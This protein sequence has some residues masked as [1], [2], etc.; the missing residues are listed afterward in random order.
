M[1]KD[2]RRGPR[3]PPT[4]PQPQPKHKQ[5]RTCV[6]WLIMGVALG[7]VGS[8][9]LTSKRA[10]PVAP[11]ETAAGPEGTGQPPAAKPRFMFEEILSDNEVDIGQTPPPPP[12]APRPQPPATPPT[13]VDGRTATPELPPAEPTEQP[14]A[15]T[16][17]V[18]VG[19]FGRAADA[20]RLRAQLALLGLSTSVQSAT[21]ANGKTTHRVRTGGYASKQEAE[22]VRSLLKKHGKDS[23]AFPIK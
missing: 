23:L 5:N 8:N 15:G 12:S 17:V 16:Y 2:Y 1:S 6:W 4:P 13:P 9:A 20:E 7:G 18:Q 19:S 3:L 10:G 14:R 11:A 21:L 22:K